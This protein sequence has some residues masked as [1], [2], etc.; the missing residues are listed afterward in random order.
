LRA[1]IES[2]NAGRAEGVRRWLCLSALADQRGAP[3]QNWADGA[4]DHRRGRWPTRGTSGFPAN[5]GSLPALG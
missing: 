1:R 2:V 5:S 3:Q 4:D